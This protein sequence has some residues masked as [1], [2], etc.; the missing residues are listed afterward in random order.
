VVVDRHVGEKAAAHVEGQAADEDPEGD[1]EQ[2]LIGGGRAAELKDGH[3]VPGMEVRSGVL[4][5]GARGSISA[6]QA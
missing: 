5:A 3:R 6:E 4:A 1:R 2:S